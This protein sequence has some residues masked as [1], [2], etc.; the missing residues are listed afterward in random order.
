MGTGKS[1]AAKI[2]AN[3]FDW[4]LADTDRMMERETGMRIADYYRAAGAEAFEEKEM[5]LINRVRYYHEAVIAMGGNYPM[6]AWPCDFAFCQTL[7]SGRAGTPPCRETAD[8]G[9]FRRRRLRSADAPQMDKMERP[10]RSRHQHN[11]YP[12]RADRTP[13]GQVH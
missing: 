1:R 9:L 12:S 2:L 5:A 13:R 10:R 6:T 7:P 11:E 3:G 4:Q 8:Y